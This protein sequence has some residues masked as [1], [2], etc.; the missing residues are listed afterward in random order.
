[1]CLNI[2]V[3]YKGFE[4]S[5]QNMK[6]LKSNYK[7]KKKKDPGQTQTELRSLSGRKEHV[8]IS[9]V[10]V[11]K[12]CPP[13]TLSSLVSKAKRRVTVSSPRGKAN[14]SSPSSSGSHMC[15]WVFT[16]QPSFLWTVRWRPAPQP[17]LSGLTAVLSSRDN[18]TFFP[19]QR[20]SQHSW[21]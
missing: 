18:E 1:M 14:F 9:R 12:L 21:R 17:S 2:V 7:I 19:G 5:H 11:L 20:L 13:L 15:G 16:C 8:L 3:L 10:L 4:K 6:Y